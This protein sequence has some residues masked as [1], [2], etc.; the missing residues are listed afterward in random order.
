MLFEGR[1]AYLAC[2]AV[3][4]GFGSIPLSP[5]SGKGLAQGGGLYTWRR[6]GWYNQVRRQTAHAGLS[7]EDGP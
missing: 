4:P 7:K 6:L 5:L 1:C 3:R 2:E